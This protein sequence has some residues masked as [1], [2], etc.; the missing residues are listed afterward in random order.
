[1]AAATFFD[2]LADLDDFAT[3]SVFLTEDFAAVDF[4]AAYVTGA[5]IRATDTSA[6]VAKALS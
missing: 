6:V 2:G 3:F 4:V 1:M 5:V